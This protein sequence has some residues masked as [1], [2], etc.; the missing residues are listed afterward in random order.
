MDKKPKIPETVSRED[1]VKDLL[2]VQE[3]F[4]TDLNS[5]S[6]VTRDYYR[7]NGKYNDSAISSHFGSFRNAVKTV[8]K[9]DKNITR[10]DIVKKH[11]ISNVK[12]KTFFISSVIA[13]ASTNEKYLKTLKT[14]QRERGAE[15]ILLST[16]GVVRGDEYY[17]PIIEDYFPGCKFVE[18]VFNDNLVAIDMR[19]SPQMQHPLTGLNRLSHKG[20]SY[21]VAHPKQDME[22]VPTH[23]ALTPHICWST[24]SITTP[25]YSDTRI[26]RFSSKQHVNGGLVVEVEDNNYF[27]VRQVQFNKDGSF[28]DL[29]KKYTPNGVLK[30]QTIV[31][32]T[33]GDIHSGWVDENARRATF[34][35]IDFLKPKKVFAG[36]V[37]DGSS[38]SHHN[39]HNLKAKYNLPVH[40][41]TL[42]NELHTYAKE[43]DRYFK[44]FPKLEFNLVY[45]NHEDHL[46]RYLRE[47]RYHKDIPENHYLSL[48][49]AKW[50]LDGFNPLEKWVKEYYPHLSKTC[51]WLKMSDSVII[52][53]VQMSVHGHI[54]HSGAKGSAKTMNVSYGKSNTGHTHSACISGESYIA[55][56]MCI[57]DMP[58]T[59]GATKWSHSN[60]INYPE[61]KRTIITSFDG[62]YRI[63]QDNRKLKSKKKPI[64][65]K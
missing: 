18:Y 41:K 62:K 40:V 64:S 39:E 54:S 4:A 37:F 17:D 10:D 63:F 12:N 19:L 13:G 59:G 53:G 26:G 20:K 45:G 52:D 14:F 44:A 50:M 34:D 28:Q 9:N 23:Q 15:I 65:K 61:G 60:I 24:G 42:F 46:V 49:L 7:Q 38:I 32:M 11:S 30:N 31:S 57:F 35:Q 3:K 33:L 55:G 48:D 6:R 5:T 25:Y 16:I 22:V 36:D 29:D 56:C 8:F 58:Y 2:D 47:A 43:L 27:H 1:I 21:I 51:K